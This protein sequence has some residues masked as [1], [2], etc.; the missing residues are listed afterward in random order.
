MFCCCCF[1]FW[2]W[3][4]LR[5]GSNFVVMFW[6]GLLVCYVLR[7][8]IGLWMLFGRFFL[9][10]RVGFFLLFWEIS[11]FWFKWFVLMMVLM[12]WNWCLIDFSVEVEVDVL[13]FF[14][15]FIVGNWFVL[16]W[17][18]ERWFGDKW[19]VRVDFYILGIVLIYM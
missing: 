18:W 13:I 19:F 4:W 9:R 2:S 8:G 17:C 14:L 3:K 7:F 16:M 10:V 6:W 11:Y 15:W 12:W 1:L 5:I